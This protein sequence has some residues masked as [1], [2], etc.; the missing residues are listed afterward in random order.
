MCLGYI[1]ASVADYMHHSAAK[2]SNESSAGS[3]GGA[4]DLTARRGGLLE[5]RPGVGIP[6]DLQAGKI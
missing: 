6:V 3:L 5:E 1:L 4:K 2:N